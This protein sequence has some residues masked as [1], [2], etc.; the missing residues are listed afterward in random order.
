MGFFNSLSDT[1]LFIYSHDDNVA[2]LL[3]Y[4]DDLI[5]TGNDNSMLDKFVSKLADRFSIKDLGP[6]NY[7]LGVEV[8]SMS[9]GLFLT[10]HKYIRDILTRYNI[11]GAKDVHTHLSIRFFSI[12]G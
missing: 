11:F 5:L 12:I 3:V 10:Q 8:I 4:V 2:Y 1:S 6:L 9:T 7:F